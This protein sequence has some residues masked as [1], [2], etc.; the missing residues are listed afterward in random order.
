ME[1][2]IPR[3]F[4]KNQKPK[5]SANKLGEYI[6]SSPSRR[7]TIVKD[8]KYPKGYIVTRYNG[9]KKGII[10]YFVNGKGD[11]RI[12]E[13][14]VKGLILKS[15]NT[16]FRRKDNELSIQALQIFASNNIPSVEKHRTSRFEKNLNNLTIEGVNVSVQPD[17]LIQGEISGKEFIGAIKIHISKTFSLSEMSGKYVSV[18]VHRFL[19]SEYPNKNIRPEFCISLD[20]F[21]GKFFTAPRA[22]KSLRKDIEAACNEIR[23]LWNDL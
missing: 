19:E 12:I 1:N 18:L 10:D 8:Q 3:N 7:K 5:I 23:L 21:T 4:K 22:F 6:N 20:I 16:D 17:I 13:E 15:Y 11:R 2:T 9:A 14:Q